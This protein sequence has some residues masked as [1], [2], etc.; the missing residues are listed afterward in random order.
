MRVL[1]EISKL[2]AWPLLIIVVLYQKTLS[3]DHGLLKIFYPYGYCKFYPSCSEYAR[4]VLRDQGIIGIP[5]IF[6]RV[7]SCTPSSLGGID[8]P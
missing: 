1:K 8:H 5:K 2:L 4:I 6:K 3:P 7:M